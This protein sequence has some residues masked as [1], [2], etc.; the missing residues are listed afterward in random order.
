[1][2]KYNGLWCDRIRPSCTK[3][4]SVEDTNA[5]KNSTMSAIQNGNIQPT[6]RVDKTTSFYPNTGCNNSSF[7]QIQQQN[8]GIISSYNTNAT[9]SIDHK[10]PQQNYKLSTLAHPVKV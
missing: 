5:A 3:N 1:M 8:G 10:V 2:S 4:E 9:M 6:L 7:H